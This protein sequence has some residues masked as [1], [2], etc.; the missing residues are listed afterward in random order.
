M[1]QHLSSR[2]AQR[3]A[4]ETLTTQR[5]ASAVRGLAPAAALL[6]F[7]T[8]AHALGTIDFTQA[9]T[10]FT[11]VKTF[12]VAVGALMVVCGLIFAAVRMMGGRMAEGALGVLGACIGGLVVG[13]GPGWINSLSGQAVQ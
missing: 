9:H 2:L 10:F 5:A 7:A 4:R 6:L 11:T 3:W 12:V 1:T 8:V 13:L